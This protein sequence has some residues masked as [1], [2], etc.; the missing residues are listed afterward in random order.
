MARQERDCDV[1]SLAVQ[2]KTVARV[3]GLSAKPVCSEFALSRIQLNPKLLAGGILCALKTVTFDVSE[4]S[5]AVLIYQ[6][7]SWP[8]ARHN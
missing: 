7:A 8:A 5:S 2:E 1:P 4:Q 3:F 6:S